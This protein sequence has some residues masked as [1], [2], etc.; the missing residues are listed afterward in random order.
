MNTIIDSKKYFLT[1]SGATVIENGTSYSKLKYDLPGLIKKDSSILYNTIRCIHAEFPSSFYIV[2]EYNNIL[3]ISTGNITIPLGNYNANTFMQLLNDKLLPINMK[4]EFDTT[5]GK[6]SFAYNTEFQILSS[7]TCYKLIGLQQK[8]YNSSG[9]IINCDFPANFLGTNLLDT[10]FG[11]QIGATADAN[12]IGGVNNKE[13]SFSMAFP[14]IGILNN[15]KMWPAWSD[16]N[17]EIELVLNDLNNFTAK[18]DGA[19]NITGYTVSNCEFVCECLELSPESYN[20]VLARHQDKIILKTQSYTFGSSSLLSAGSSA[21]TYDIP[22]Q[23]KL[24]S[25]KQIMW[26]INPSDSLDKMAGGVNANLESWQFISSSTGYPSRPVQC[27]YGAEAFM[28]NQKSFGSVYSSSHSGNATRTEFNVASTAY[29]MYY[30]PYAK[31]SSIAT[32]YL[33]RSNKFYQ[34]LDLEQIN[35]DKASLYS[36]I[37]TNST[38]SQLRLQVASQLANVNHNLYYWSCHDVMVIF[39]F[40][41]GVVSI[42]I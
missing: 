18:L 11:V 3:N 42:A 5:T 36:G 1:P 28:Q 2:N 17:L 31:I 14:L 29:N 8:Q 38:T 22:F 21:G 15:M 4:I 33:T 12:G 26:Y 9:G 23:I 6:F 39:D 35:S 32:D 25:L 10:N 27:K 7:S 37:S 19:D 41:L 30:R 16:Q 40:N 34:I 13:L 24:N 20:M